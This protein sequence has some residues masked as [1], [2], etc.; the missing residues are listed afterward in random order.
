MYSRSTDTIDK[1]F[2][3]AGLVS[4]NNYHYGFFS[5]R[6]KLPAGF[7]SGVVVAFY[8]SIL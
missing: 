5:A 2:A 3:G 1:I 7:A 6:L 4:K 8:V